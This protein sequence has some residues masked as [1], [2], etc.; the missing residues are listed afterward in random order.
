MPVISKPPPAAVSSGWW[1]P[2]KAPVATPAAFVTT[3]AS[4]L[5]RGLLHAS[6]PLTV[7]VVVASH[8]QSH[9]RWLSLIARTR[10]A[11]SIDAAAQVMS[12]YE[13]HGRLVE[14][15]EHDAMEMLDPVVASAA[16][17]LQAEHL[18]QRTEAVIAALDAAPRD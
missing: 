8:N 9:E 2:W 14:G 1:A 5:R 10:C 7:A 15:L 13:L 16:R 11:V 6:D 4:W 3:Q 12:L 17:I 18:D